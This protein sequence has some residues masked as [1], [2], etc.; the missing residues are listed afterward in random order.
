[1]LSPEEARKRHATMIRMDKDLY[2]DIADVA[3]QE[4]RSVNQQILYYVKQALE[5][6]EEEECARSQTKS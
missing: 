5:A 4:G 3:A 6:K 1:M 2:R